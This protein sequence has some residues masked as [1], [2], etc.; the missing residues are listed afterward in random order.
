MS[1]FRSLC[2]KW[3]EAAFV[4]P[5]GSL[6][7]DYD[8]DAKAKT[9]ANAFFLSLALQSLFSFL[10]VLLPSVKCNTSGK[11]SLEPRWDRGYPRNVP[12][13]CRNA[14]DG[15][16]TCGYLGGPFFS[17]SLVRVHVL[18]CRQAL[19]QKVNGINQD[20]EDIGSSVVAI[21]H[22]V[23]APVHLGPFLDHLSPRPDGIG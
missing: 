3:H 9:T 5:S 8:L 10:F 2:A 12:S 21:C 22:A 16:K 14:T 13:E 6:G 4:W 18:I 19:V 23:T 7:L 20:R 1:C 11:T 17:V 15:K